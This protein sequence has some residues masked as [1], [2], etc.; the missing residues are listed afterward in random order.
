MEF[1]ERVLNH[2]LYKKAKSDQLTYHH[3]YMAYKVE[4]CHGYFSLVIGAR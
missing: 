3:K 1:P 4:I 2:S